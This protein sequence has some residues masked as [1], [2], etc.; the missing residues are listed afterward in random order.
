MDDA[1]RSASL[2]LKRLFDMA[3]GGGGGWRVIL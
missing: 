1:L 2:C 3:G